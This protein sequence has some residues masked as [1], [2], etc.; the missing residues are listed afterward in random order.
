MAPS[1][2]PLEATPIHRSPRLIMTLLVI[3]TVSAFSQTTSRSDSQTLQAILAELRQI[4]H[5][6]QTTS[7]M[8]A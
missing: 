8:A 7:A 1:H 4:R 2:T 5:D 6:L 3:C